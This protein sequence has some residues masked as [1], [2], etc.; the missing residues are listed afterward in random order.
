MNIQ[1]AWQTFV[2]Y[3]ILKINSDKLWMNIYNR[4]KL[5]ATFLADTR[6]YIGAEHLKA[7]QYRSLI[8]VFA[9]CM[10]GSFCFARKNGK[11]SWC[12]YMI[13]PQSES[14]ENQDC[15]RRMKWITKISLWFQTA[16]LNWNWSREISLSTAVCFGT[17]TARTAPAFPHGEL[18]Q[19]NAVWIRK[20]LIP[21]SRN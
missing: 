19:R 11:R 17:V 7:N 6:T 8:C 15:K 3:D 1:K 20:R 21:H 12:A 18:L 2:L 13:V 9:V 5:S 14:N 16:F 4:I 10:C